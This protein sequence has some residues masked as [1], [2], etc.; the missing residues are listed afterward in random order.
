MRLLPSGE[1]AAGEPGCGLRG[2]KPDEGS[3]RPGESGAAHWPDDLP[4]DHRRRARDR[5]LP[6][7]AGSRPRRDAG[8][9]PQRA[10]LGSPRRALVIRAEVGAAPG[11]LDLLDPRAAAATRLA[12]APVDLEL[13]LERSFGAAGVAIV[14]DRRPF[15]VD[16][17]GQDLD[18]RLVEL[19]DLLRLQRAD[20]P[21]RVDLRE[22]ERLVG[23]DVADPGDALL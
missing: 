21:Q 14:V 3:G 11:D 13:V 17:G 2:S 22:P 23:V 10:G 5:G 9:D 18:H 4:A 1:V 19:V 15:R 6:R 20:R 16:P 8:R 7:V 12:L